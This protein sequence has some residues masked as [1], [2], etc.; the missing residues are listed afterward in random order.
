VSAPQLEISAS[1][2]LAAWMRSEGLGLAFT[3]YQIGKLF[4]LGTNADGTLSVFERTFNRCMGLW[5]DGQT[6]LMSTLYQLW[7]L[8]NMLAES[9]RYNG[10]D[11][12]YVPRVAYTTGDL[13][14][15]DI[16]LAGD[17]IVFVNTRFSCL[18][19][20][21]EKHSFCPV[22]SPP[23]IS[24][25][26]PEDR[27]HLNGVAFDAGR[28]A[29]A[30]AVAPS[31]V[32]EGWRSRRRGGGCVLEVATGET[33]AAGLSMPHSPRIHA[34]KLWMLESG[35]GHFGFVDTASGR[36]E[37]VAFCPG[38]LRGLAFAGPY[39][40]VG[41]SHH[42]DNRAFDGLPLEENL[43]RHGL[44]PRCGLQILDIRTGATTHWLH[45]EGMVAELYDVALLPKI[46]RPMAL[47]L[48]NDEIQK[49]LHVGPR[50]ALKSAP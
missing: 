39:A 8:E 20:V 30:S 17:Q 9:E 48:V 34:G 13:D 45:L 1:P 50:V 41:M 28:P 38:F 27:C 23:F 29:F 40:V 12:I 3:T 4:L 5:S 18:A 11:G 26:A 46:Q 35:T 24:Q 14:I 31:D 19:T 2:G 44:A 32:P 25:L 16:G 43:S 10:Y 36:F 7:R 42:R 21:D 33:I 37:P 49:I 15:H 47:G 6:L 22:W